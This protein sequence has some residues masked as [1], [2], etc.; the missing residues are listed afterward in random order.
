M[1]WQQLLLKVACGVGVEIKEARSH[2]ENCICTH[3]SAM[4]SMECPTVVQYLWTACIEFN[5]KKFSLLEDTQDFEIGEVGRSLAWISSDYFE[6]LLFPEGVITTRSNRMKFR[7]V[8][9]R[10]WP[11][12]QCE[13]KDVLTT[14]RIRSSLNHHDW[15]FHV[16]WQCWFDPDKDRPE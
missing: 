3:L 2:Q 14:H 7:L 8:G 16:Q 9:H 13:T 6:S 15:M 11:I 1:N 4:I 10:K 5:G 12:A